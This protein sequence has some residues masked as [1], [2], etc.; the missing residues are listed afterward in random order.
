MPL[1]IL[2]EQIIYGL[3]LGSIYAMV[4]VGFSLVLGV[5]DTPNLAHGSFYMLSSYLFSVAMETWGFSPWLAGL[6]AVSIIVL[7]GIAVEK[8]LL[9]RLYGLPPFQYAFSVILLTI[10]L[11]IAFQKFA[12]IIWGH[13]PR[14]AT[15]PHLSDVYINIGSLRIDLLKIVIVALSLGLIF[16]LDFF[17]KKTKQGRALRAVVQDREAAPLMGIN[18]SRLF[19]FC[20]ALSIG[21]GAIAGCLVGSVYSIEPEMGAGMLGK[22]FVIVI[23][24]GFGNIRAALVA[25]LLLGIWENLATSIMPPEFIYAAEFLLLIIFFLLKGADL[26][27]RFRRL[28]DG[29]V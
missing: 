3:V 23:L 12:G 20:F 28:H 8:G 24:A 10:G 6:I 16:A 27:S 14:Y 5:M 29:G 15:I 25:S 2:L 7:L 11:D 18:V 21:L 17:I 4:S 22:A 19:T 26:I 1:D 13:W 9:A